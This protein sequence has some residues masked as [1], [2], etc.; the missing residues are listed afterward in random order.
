MI[1]LV[2]GNCKGFPVRDSSVGRGTLGGRDVLMILLRVAIE[3]G[4]N[5]RM[6]P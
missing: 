6:M 5:C 2:P 3:L 1:E 4:N